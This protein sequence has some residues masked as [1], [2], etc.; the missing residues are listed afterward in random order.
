MV[1]LIAE[2]LL[3]D[4]SLPNHDQINLPNFYAH[5]FHYECT[6]IMYNHYRLKISL[7]DLIYIK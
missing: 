1:Y 5:I 4:F 2:R 7:F 3:I 6:C